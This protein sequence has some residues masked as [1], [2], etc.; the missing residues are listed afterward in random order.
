MCGIAGHLAFPRADSGVVKNMV[1]ALS[2]RGPDGMGTFASGPIALGHTRLAIIDLAT[3]DQPM[4]NENRQVVVVFN[5][6]IYN[7]RELRA[8]LAPRHR[9]TSESDT[10]VLVHLYEDFGDGMVARLDGM[11]AF[12]IWDAQRERLLAARDRFGE[13]PFLFVNDERGFFFASEVV[14]L[15]AAGVCGD[16]IDRAALSD[17]LR[18]LYIP[19][20]RTIWKNVSKLPAGHLLTV[21][22]Q[23]LRISSYWQPPVPGLRPTATVGAER[24]GA[25]LRRSVRSRLRS[26]VPMGALLSGGVDSS[27]VVALMAEELGPGVKTFSV[28]FGRDD[29]EVRFAKLVAD[30]YRTD[31]HEI[32]VTEDLISQVSDAFALFSEPLGDSSAVPTAAVFREVAKH[33]KVVLTGDGGDELF[34]GYDRHRLVERLPHLPRLAAKWPLSGTLQ[35][36]W[37]RRAQ[38][39]MRAM[40]STGIARNLALIEVFNAADRHLLLGPQGE[41]A[42]DYAAIEPRGNANAAMAFDVAVYLPDDML[43]K[44]DIAS[45]GA[46]V[47]SRAPLLDH[48]LAECVIPEPPAAKLG[49]REGKLLLKRAVESLVPAPILRRPKRGFGSPVG[50]WLKGPLRQFFVDSLSTNA[51]ICRWLDPAAVARTVRETVSGSANPQQGWALLAL[52]SWAQKFVRDM[53]QAAT[54]SRSRTLERGSHAQF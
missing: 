39:L 42:A 21:D 40:G 46:A 5:G 36:A 32:M 20:P 49:R 4:F 47:E 13:K 9:F 3:G 24:I 54:G 11:F 53:P 31:H 28:G 30:R 52:E 43:V 44:V 10:E 12:V 7:Y 38:R 2:H 22:R 34:G 18:L 15:G 33:V 19:A 48:K 6:E 14:A 25:E 50:E 41:P 35:Y 8:E 1:A 23:G 16:E 17:Y 51:T 27:T 26:D 45:M 29:D 37:A